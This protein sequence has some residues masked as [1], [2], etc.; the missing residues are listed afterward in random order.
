M[1]AGNPNWKKGNPSGNPS[2]KRTGQITRVDSKT[3]A[4]CAQWVAESYHG[5]PKQSVDVDLSG[6]IEHRTLVDLGK[7]A[8]EELGTLERLLEKSALADG[9]TD[10]QDAELVPALSPELPATSEAPPT[11]TET[12]TK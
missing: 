1:P 6:A 8:H 10:S 2:G 7:L 9:L 11:A 3:R 4:L 5:K 12:Q